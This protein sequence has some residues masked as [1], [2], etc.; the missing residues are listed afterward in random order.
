MKYQTS[1]RSRSAHSERLKRSLT[2][3]RPSVNR[4]AW[5]GSRLLHA[6]GHDAGAGLDAGKHSDPVCI[7]VGDGD[8]DRVDGL[9]R[10]VDHPDHGRCRPARGLPRPARSR[11]GTCSAAT[12]AVTV[13]PRRKPRR[14]IIERDPDPL[15]AADRVGLRRDL[16]DRALR[17]GRSG[18]ARARRSKR[19]PALGEAPTSSVGTSMTASRS[20]GARDGDHGLAGGNDLADLGAD[21]GHHPVEVGDGSGCSRA[22]LRRSSGSRGRG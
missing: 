13:V 14:R 21:G 17:P 20:S 9:R 4:T 19:A 6:G 8:V 22:A 11:P 15:G 2:S 10:S 12:T 3:A 7:E 16:A 1:E 18:R 5:P